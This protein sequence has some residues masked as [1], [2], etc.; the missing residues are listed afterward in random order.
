MTPMAWRLTACAAI[1]A[2]GGLSAPAADPPVGAGSAYQ[3]SGSVTLGP[4]SSPSAFPSPAASGVRPLHAA[5]LGLADALCSEA[6]RDDALLSDVC[7]LDEQQGW[8]VGDRGVI[9]HTDDG[10][11][12]WHV[13]DS[14][15]S[16]PLDSVC[17]ISP[18]T[19]WAAGGFGHPFLHT[20][21]GVVL[22]T[23]DGGR[24]WQANTKLLVPRLRQLHFFSTREGWAVGGASAMFPSGVF[25][26]HS[27]GQSFEP[28]PGG[29]TLGWLCGWFAEPGRGV[30]AGGLGTTA[31]VTSSAIQHAP[32][33]LGLGGVNQMR[34]ARTGSGWLVG[35]G[36]L[37]MVTGD[38]GRTW[39]PPLGP[40]PPSA[41]QFDFAALA[42]HGQKCWIAGSPGSKVF[43]T[44]DGGRSWTVL[45]TS[46][47]LPISALAMIDERRGWAVGALGVILATAD[48][49]QSWQPQHAANSRAAV[50]GLFSQPED[51]PLELIARL[52]GNEGY[53]VAIEV[54][55]RRDVE[56]RPRDS[57]ELPD[58]LREAVA[59]VGG[60]DA[61]L[62]WQFPLRQKGLAQTAE[63][64]IDTWD[65]A[66]AGHGMEQLEAHVVRLICQWRPDVIVVGEGGGDPASRL[67]GQVVVRAA[68]KAAEQASWPEQIAQLGLGPWQAKK[69]Y[70]ALPADVHGTID[71]ATA[72]L[73]TRL[74]RSLSELAAQPRSL[75]VDRFEAP[76]QTL[77][78][79]TLGS[80]LAAESE[81]GDF[82]TG[83]A[84]A[85]GGDAR[86]LL[87]DAPA[88][89][90]DLL[91]RSAQQ[92]RNAQA[93]FEHALRDRQD[94]GGLLAK[95]RVL[96]AGLDPDGAAWLLYRLGQRYYQTGQW[97]LAAETCQSIVS[98]YPAHP[99]SRPAALWLLQYYSSSSAAWRA[100]CRQRAAV[101]PTANVTTKF[102]SD[103]QLAASVVPLAAYL[104][105]N[106]PVLFAE[107]ALQFS[108]AAAYRRLGQPQPAERLYQAAARSAN[109]D[110]WR[111]AAEGELWLAAASG[112][113]A[114]P[115]PVLHCVTATKRPH[116]D[117][118]LDDA[119]WK[120]ARG[121]P[122]ESPHHEDGEWPAE[123]KLAY[124]REFLYVAIR[125][126]QS[127]QARYELTAGPRPRDADLSARDRVEL[128]LDIDR[129]LA[130]YYRFTIDYR[131]WTADSCWGDST[132]DPT[133]Y[134]A[135]RQEDGFWT[136]EAAI[137]FDQLCAH[138]PQP[139]E[140]WGLG[141]QRTVPGVGFQSWSQPAAA[142]VIPEGFGYLIFDGA[143]P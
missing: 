20:S 100:E 26:T 59:A 74:G 31:T 18:T 8:A 80:Q 106:Q 103:Q 124:D 7:F 36:G 90:V 68:S 46:Q 83:I 101:Q 96:I 15:V 44:P 45:S 16:C 24:H 1:L 70:A 69:L 43:Y 19:G 109:H 2:A 105:Q 126:R 92:R 140:V 137:P 23:Q 25:Q 73:A 57:G 142:A 75:L 78:F 134:V 81:R 71:V 85:P 48:G 29:D 135:A 10:G 139:R 56:V 52:G 37:V 94:G 102:Q 13:Q 17:F 66:N 104:E 88:E 34:V 5:D 79:R 30:V 117:G 118:R 120:Q 84:L 143:T 115:K 21:S 50:L 89:T 138:A 129:G 33:P 40:V 47:C 108:L 55:N 53:R 54:L 32:A 113:G 110:A 133:W 35:D 123:V 119:V 82:L 122:L 132:W 39:R 60:C 64:V 38:G 131:G 97:E 9:W 41:R 6:M 87:Q 93:I 128:L 111:T 51:V 22:A 91:A 116:L 95:A 130:S 141:I 11:R 77:G 112:R 76:P 12:H 63:Q 99:L 28:V 27:G 62:A 86:R 125:C 58:R 72:Q 107:P 4:E 136:A 98:G 42:I 3:S 14:G 67:I 114:A 61:R 49:S 121:M 127:L 65:S